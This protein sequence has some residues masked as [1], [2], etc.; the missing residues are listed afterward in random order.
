M[1]FKFSFLIKLTLYLHNITEKLL[2]MVILNIS[3]C[4]QLFVGG[5][6]SYLRCSVR[7]CLQLFV[8]GYMSQVV[9]WRGHGLFSMVGQL[10]T[11]TLLQT[12]G[13]KDEPNIVNKTC[14]LLQTTGGKDEP[15]I[16]NKT[17]TLFAS[18]CL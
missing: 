4:L 3:L 10:V 12:T 16:E 17:C 18:S 13:G 15:N 14:T 11:C 1:V 2:K 6:M 5:Y 7:L 9:C 8:G